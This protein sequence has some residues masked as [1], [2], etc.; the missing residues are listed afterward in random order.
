MASAALL[1]ACLLILTMQNICVL[2]YKELL[3]RQKGKKAERL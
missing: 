3:K 2:T 1:L